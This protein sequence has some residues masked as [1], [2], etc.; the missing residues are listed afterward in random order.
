M[1]QHLTKQDQTYYSFISPQRALF[2]KVTISIHAPNGKS[3]STVCVKL[4]SALM[5]WVNT[6]AFCKIILVASGKNP[7]W[8]NLGRIQ[9]NDRS[10]LLKSSHS[11]RRVSERILTLSVLC[12]FLC[13]PASLS[14]GRWNPPPHGVMAVIGSWPHNIP[15]QKEIVSSSKIPEEGSNWPCLLRCFFMSQRIEDLRRGR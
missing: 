1:L 2:I 12:A 5:L 8:T 7:N 10:N 11:R 14:F 4:Q 9:E 3:G 6:P 13:Q 15:H